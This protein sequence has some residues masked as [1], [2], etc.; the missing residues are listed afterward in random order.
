MKKQRILIATHDD[1][2]PST[3]FEDLADKP[4]AQTEYNVYKTLTAL[5]HDVD[6]L[7]IGDQLTELRD[8]IRD[9][10]PHVVFNLLEQFSGIVTYD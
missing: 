6:M 8:T 10:K 4:D 2:V 7:G 1:L 9:W 5:G 3:D